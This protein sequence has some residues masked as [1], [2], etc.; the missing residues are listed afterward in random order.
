MI[1][2]NRQIINASVE[3]ILFPHLAL[4]CGLALKKKKKH[5]VEE[6]GERFGFRKKK[7]YGQKL[8]KS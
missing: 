5:S 8:V 1:H 3:P 7:I 4:I 6:K 2:E